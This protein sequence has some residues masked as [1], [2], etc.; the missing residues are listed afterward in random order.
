MTLGVPFD[1]SMHNF[2]LRHYLTTGGLDPDRDVQIQ[3]VRPPDM[4]AQLVSGNIDGY[5]GPDPFNQRAVFQGAGFIHVLTRDLW[6]GHPCCGFAV[7]ESF[8]AANP[9]TYRAL[10]R[11]VSDSAQWA[12][13][14][15]NRVQAA[16]AMAPQ[17][18]LNQ[19]P[20][21]V[22]AVLTG[23]FDDGSGAHRQVADRIGF[24]PFPWQSF[25]VWMLAQMQRWE[26]APAGTYAAAPDLA[27]AAARVFDTA[28]AR[29]AMAAVGSTPP[30]DDARVEQVMGTA[31]DPADAMRWTE[32]FVA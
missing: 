9:V 25:A 26:L 28:T 2:L 4:V 21:V 1:F 13:A 7:Q 30:A 12:N 23:D 31:F 17:A 5:L 14:A 22:Q 27:A 20:E 29:E 18:Y 11:A 16:G 10:L 3:V 8:A 6:A 19:P 15:A 32:R 24:E